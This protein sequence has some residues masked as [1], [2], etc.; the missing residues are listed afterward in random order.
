MFNF[1]VNTFLD[2]YLKKVVNFDKVDKL[3]DKKHILCPENCINEPLE[4]GKVNPLVQ[5]QHCI[6]KPCMEDVGIVQT[7]Y[8]HNNCQ[9]LM[10]GCRQQR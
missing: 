5:D 9:S 10:H 8:Y 7:K 6:P 1:T 3:I 2:A 4:T